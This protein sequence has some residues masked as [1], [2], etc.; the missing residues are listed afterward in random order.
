MPEAAPKCDRFAFVRAPTRRAAGPG[1]L[2]SS[3]RSLSPLER[4][5]VGAMYASIG[6][7]HVVGFGLLAFVI[8]PAHYAGLGVGVALL[9]YSLGLRHAFDADHLAAIDNATRRALEDRRG[10]SRP[11]PLSFGYFFSLGHSTI[12]VAMGVAIIVAERTVL[13][14]VTR[15]S[16]GL[17]Q[18][19]GLFGTSVSAAFLLLI[20]ILN[21]VVL[22]GI[23]RAFVAMLAGRY[24][25]A[26][27]ERQLA[28]RGLLARLFGRVLRLVDKEWHLYPV[29]VLFGLGFDTATEVALLATTAL[30]ASHHVPWYA[31]V[32]LP[33]LFTAG[34]SLMDTTDGVFMNAAYGWAFLH[35]VRKL[36]YNLAITGLSVAICF[37]IGGIEVLGI[38]P[39]EVHGLAHQGFF[40]FIDSISINTA[41]FVIV[42]LFVLTWIVA[43][44]VWRLGRLEERASRVPAAA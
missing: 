3:L 19:G 27:L 29:G 41:G 11:R 34:M 30:Y 20:G 25:D 5:R 16:S 1:S 42:G 8:V 43:S 24:D 2:R 13:S 26:E 31:I 28:N 10:T 15:P 35:P 12:V 33:V 18:F 21:L 17:S 40:R 23:V 6:A 32:S 7:L 39:M 36:Y 44:L 22:A 37:V 4:R 38:V 9:A 14:A